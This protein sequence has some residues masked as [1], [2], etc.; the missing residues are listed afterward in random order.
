MY[1][2]QESI[3]PRTGVLEKSGSTI[4]IATQGDVR[5]IGF[6]KGV[7]NDRAYYYMRYLLH[8]VNVRMLDIPATEGVVPSELRCLYGWADRPPIEGEWKVVAEE[9]ALSRVLWQRVGV[10]SC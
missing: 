7:R 5:E 10:T 1:S 4:D 2:G 9:S 8:P 6:D 3:L